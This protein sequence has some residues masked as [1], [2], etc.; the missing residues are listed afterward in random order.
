MDNKLKLIKARKSYEKVR[1]LKKGCNLPFFVETDGAS[2]AHNKLK[3]EKSLDPDKDWKNNKLGYI[4]FP[5]NEHK[6]YKKRLSE[7]KIIYTTRVSN[8]VGKYKINKIYNSSFG[9]LKVTYFKHF[10]D[11]KDHPFYNELK[12]KQIKILSKKKSILHKMK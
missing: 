1:I 9:K 7:N 2:S 5:K 11:I 3:K 12:E 6:D 8:E 10:S 4:D